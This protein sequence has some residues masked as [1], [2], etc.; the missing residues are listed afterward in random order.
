MA[1]RRPY[2]WIQKSG[3]KKHKGA[4]HRALGYGREEVIPTPVLRRAIHQGGHLGHM[5]Q[6]ALNVRGLRGRHHPLQKRRA[7]HARTR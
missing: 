2:K 4:L 6:F 1:K 5:A 7:S 3:V